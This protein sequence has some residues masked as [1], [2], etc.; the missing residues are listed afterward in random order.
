MRITTIEG[1]I[2]F[3]SY[4]FQRFFERLL[5]LFL[6]LPLAAGAASSDLRF[7]PAA[8]EA[9][10]LTTVDLPRPSPESVLR[11]CASATDQSADASSM[12]YLGAVKS[13]VR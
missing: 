8:L 6:I 2:V 10:T 4:F 5:R 12:A 7:C 1:T 11:T 13:R 9:L 3:E